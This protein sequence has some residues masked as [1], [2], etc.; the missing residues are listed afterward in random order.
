MNHRSHRRTI[1][2]F[3]A[4]L[5]APLA[6]TGCTLYTNPDPAMSAE[7]RYTP[8]RHRGY[9]VYYDSGR[10]YYVTEGRRRYI[11]RESAHYHRYKRHYERHHNG[12]AY[13]EWR[14]EHRPRYANPRRHHEPR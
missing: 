5:A 7:V 10:P 13:R 8:L 2:V 12:R 1:L 6:A 11:P 4:A 9:I 3:L 14:R